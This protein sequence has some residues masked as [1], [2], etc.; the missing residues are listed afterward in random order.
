MVRISTMLRAPVYEWPKRH[1][2]GQKEVE[3]GQSVI[4]RTEGEKF[5]KLMKL[6]VQE[7]RNKATSPI[8]MV[9]RVIQPTL[10]DLKFW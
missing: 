7:D 8:R 2:E 10:K 1:S 9:N 4:A 5:R 6:A 3:D